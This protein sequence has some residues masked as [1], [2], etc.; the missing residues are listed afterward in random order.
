MFCKKCGAHLSEHAK[1]CKK[2]G[3]KVERISEKSQKPQKRSERRKE[4]IEPPPW[5][6]RILLVVCAAIIF[7]VTVGTLLVN[8][9]G[10]N[11][12]AEILST[13]VYGRATDEKYL[14]IWDVTYEFYANGRKY[15]DTCQL[16]GPQGSI[17]TFG[18]HVSYLSFAPEVSRLTRG[19][20]VS[21]LN[22][23][24]DVLKVGSGAIF[25]FLIELLVGYFLLWVAFPKLP[26]FGFGKKKKRRRKKK[27]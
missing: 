2:C 6:M 14:Y 27:P 7:C 13:S 19:S 25:Y 5:P 1:F 9:I 11:A 10:K 20:S 4:K 8:F 15:V 3:A 12:E 21:T 22:R 18:Y 23:L 16:T 24:G 17:N 26:F